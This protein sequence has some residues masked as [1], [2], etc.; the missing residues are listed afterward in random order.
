I[1][2]EKDLLPT[3]LVHRSI[4]ENKDLDIVLRLAALRKYLEYTE[5]NCIYENMPY[6]IISSLIKGRTRSEI[7]IANNKKNKMGDDQYEEG[8]Q[9]IKNYLQISDFDYEYLLNNEFLPERLID[10][11]ESETNSYIKLQLFRAYYERKKDF[12]KELNKND[13]IIKK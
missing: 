11:Y 4:F 13:P 6:N 9:E 12:K 5:K 3:T 1:D 10:K 2:V 8:C 7:N